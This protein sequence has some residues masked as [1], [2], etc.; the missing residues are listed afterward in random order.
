MQASFLLLPSPLTSVQPVLSTG[1]EGV[2]SP[3]Y[4]ERVTLLL[5]LQIPQVNK[6]GLTETNQEKRLSFWKQIGTLKRKGDVKPES[7]LAFVHGIC[8]FF[9]TG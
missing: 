1:E 9:L 3:Q 2:S 8:H 4:G 6:E 7:S 5:D